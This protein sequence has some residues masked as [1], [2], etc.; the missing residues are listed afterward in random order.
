ME[1]IHTH[2][3]TDKEGDK[4]VAERAK[5]LSKQRKEEGK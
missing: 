5:G 2:T 3:H 1:Y 4:R